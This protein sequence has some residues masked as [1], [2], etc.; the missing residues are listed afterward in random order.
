MEDEIIL[1]S[2][3]REMVRIS[4]IGGKFYKKIPG[5]DRLP[6]RKKTVFRRKKRREAEDFQLIFSEI[7]E[8]QTFFILTASKMG[9]L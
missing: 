7:L 6:I 3:Q 5:M 8:N 1:I 4:T 9:N 2:G